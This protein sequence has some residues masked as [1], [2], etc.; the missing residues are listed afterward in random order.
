MIPKPASAIW[1][2]SMDFL[3]EL[4]DPYITIS[5][6]S[7]LSL[8]VTLWNADKLIWSKAGAADLQ[9]RLFNPEL[10]RTASL[11][12]LKPF[13]SHDEPALKFLRRVL[14]IS[15]ISVLMLLFVYSAR[16]P[17]L[18]VQVRTRDGV[19][20]TWG[21]IIRHILLN[22]LTVV[23][24]VNYVSYSLYPWTITWLE[25]DVTAVRA[26]LVSIFDII[27]RI[28]LYFVSSAIVYSL[29]AKYFGSFGGSVETAVSSTFTTFL[30][31]V[32]LGNMAGVYFYAAIVGAFPIYTL[33]IARAF[34]SEGRIGT[35]LRYV[36]FLLPFSSKPIR[37]AAVT[38]GVFIL[39]SVFLSVAVARSFVCSTDPCA[40]SSRDICSP[41][42]Q[43]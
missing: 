41:C 13:L 22:G 32:S 30:Y 37:S 38:V 18:L 33:A 42:P 29:F 21:P 20:L 39:V 4:V 5:G 26:V 23:F 31:S 36:F 11:W 9:D 2:A 14:V 12:L 27:L 6:L 35:A 28:S 24:T 16:V 10:G 19:S 15:A 43:R 25:K 34:T 7:L 8:F 17:E 3:K 40:P 1:C